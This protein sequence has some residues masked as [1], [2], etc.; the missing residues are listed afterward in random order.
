MRVIATDFHFILLCEGLQYARRGLCPRLGL[1]D[2]LIYPASLHGA[3]QRRAIVIEPNTPDYTFYLWVH[4]LP[5]V[6][7][8][9][10]GFDRLRV[11]ISDMMIKLLLFSR[12]PKSAT[13][14][15]TLLWPW[16]THCYQHRPLVAWLQTKWWAIILF[17]YP[18]LFRP[19]VCLS[20]T[21]ISLRKHVR[22][23][24]LQ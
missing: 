7:R 3:D 24:F 15:F 17:D 19:I 2:L 8:I 23:T 13:A 11:V 6:S 10:V 9:I 4:H 5:P 12:L 18:D 16:F 21:L 1:L 20:Q 22:E 14:F